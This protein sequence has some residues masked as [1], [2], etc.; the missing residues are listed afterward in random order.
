M[1]QLIGWGDLAR[2]WAFRLLLGGGG[3]VLAF[4]SGCYARL[5]AEGVGALVNE[6]EDRE[7]RLGLGLRTRPRDQGPRS[8]TSPKDWDSGQRLRG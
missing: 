4:T 7:P 5:V 1:R 3:G 6:N 2:A 8:D